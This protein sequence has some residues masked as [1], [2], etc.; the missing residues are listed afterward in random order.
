[1][2]EI[3]NPKPWALD[4]VRHKHSFL[5]P[6]PE[7]TGSHYSPPDKHGKPYSPLSKGLNLVRALSRFPCQV[8]GVTH[9]TATQV[10]VAGKDCGLAEG[11]ETAV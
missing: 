1:M 9:W 5:S 8:P 2:S 7:M 4:E 10:R 11:D 3:A 6:I